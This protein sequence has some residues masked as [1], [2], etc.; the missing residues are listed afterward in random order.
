[1]TASIPTLEWTQQKPGGDWIAPLPVEGVDCLQIFAVSRAGYE[2]WY[3][4]T[5]DEFLGWFATEDEAK[6][7]G[8]T[9]V[10]DS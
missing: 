4:G 5:Q 10:G 2:L 8:R 7:A 6:A 9:W 1:M 3:R